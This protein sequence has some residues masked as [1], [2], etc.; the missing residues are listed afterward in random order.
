[1]I[2]AI[3]ASVG[4]RTK[5]ALPAFFCIR[6][7]RI[8]EVKFAA[9]MKQQDVLI[10]RLLAAYIWENSRYHFYCEIDT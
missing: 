2:K 7:L 8:A 9:W 1:M 4:V 3:F 6:I 10:L 5:E